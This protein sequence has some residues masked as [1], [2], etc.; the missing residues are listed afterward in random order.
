MTKGLQAL[1]MISS[2]YQRSSCV[3]NDKQ[4]LQ[5]VCRCYKQQVTI[6]GGL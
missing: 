5:K 6:I 2:N 3:A 4:Q 1:Q